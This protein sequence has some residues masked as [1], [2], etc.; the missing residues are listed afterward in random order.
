MFGK[1]TETA[2]SAITCLAG[3][4]DNPA[5]RLSAK[6]IAVLRGIPT[7][8]VAKVL[9]ALAQ[10]G[11]VSGT[12]GPGGGYRLT[13][14]P[15]DITLKSISGVFERGSAD[16]GAML[17]CTS[18]GSDVPLPVRQKLDRLSDALDD[19]LC[20]T[21]LDEFCVSGPIRVRA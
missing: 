7:P 18:L 2:I 17:C 16:L 4:W 14:A 9:S 15:H 3:V 21:T 8:I 11:L 10:A 19:L 6:Q 20:R 5:S 1:Q 13:K 12:P